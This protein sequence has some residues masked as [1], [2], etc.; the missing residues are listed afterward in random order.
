MEDAL[1]VSDL[2]DSHARHGFK[3][4]KQRLRRLN[5]LVIEHKENRVLALAVLV[6]TVLWPKEELAL[7]DLFADPRVNERAVRQ[8]GARFGQVER[9]LARPPGMRR[10]DEN[11]LT[12]GE[13]IGPRA[14][15]CLGNALDA[16]HA[17]KN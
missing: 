10:D 12:F 17:P 13:Q 16:A 4:I 1:V 15:D 2:H 11:L 9:D 5:G 3:L 14:A 6:V 8:S 7:G